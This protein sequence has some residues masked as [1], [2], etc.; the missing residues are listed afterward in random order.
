MLTV[1][2]EWIPKGEAY[3]SNLAAAV[4]LTDTPTQGVALPAGADTAIIYVSG[5]PCHI[6]M[7]GGAAT[8]NDPQYPASQFL[9]MENNRTSL[10]NFSIIQSAA[11]G[12]I[13]VWYF[14][15]RGA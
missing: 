2:S 9:V 3:Y 4:E 13:D 10:V 5:Q 11:S 14:S 15:V 8:T 1:P 12:R 7:S 6:S